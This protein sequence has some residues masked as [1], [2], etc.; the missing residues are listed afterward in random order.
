[1]PTPET[2]YAAVGDSDVAYQVLGRGVDDLLYFVGLGSHVDLQWDSPAL[3][4]YFDFLASLSR[5]IL[6]DR[7]GTGASDELQLNQASPPWEAWC[8][9]VAAV[10]NAVG[11]EHATIFAEVD[12]GPIAIL[13]TVSHPDRVRSLILGN[14]CARYLYNYD[15]EIGR[16]IEDLDRL[17]RDM[18]HSWGRA[19]AIRGYSSEMARREADIAAR[20]ARTQRAAATPRAAAAQ[21]RYILESLDVR[22]VLPLVRVPTLVLHTVGN[23]VVPLDH[24]RYLADHIDGA[25]FVE[26]K[27]ATVGLDP[28]D[29]HLM[30]E[31]GELLSGDRPTLP[32]SRILTTVLFTDV[33]D[34]T[35][36]A[37]SLGDSRWRG[38]LEAHDATV[39]AQ[40][41]AF[42]GREI[43]TMGDG[44][45]AEFDGPA[46]AIQCATSISHE[47]RRLGISVRCGVHTGECEVRGRDLAGLTVHIA[48]RIGALAGPDEVLASRTVTDIM[49]GSTL[50][51]APVGEH[52]LKG[53]PG[54]WM[55]FRTVS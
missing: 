34:S 27:G 24:G 5:L 40:L 49:A 20:V 2:R 41:R 52:Q 10:L 50:R 25:R 44:F 11:S 14:T 51:F 29:D 36:H 23:S 28:T 17:V 33:V 21:Y 15:Y 31:L 46:R 38:L 35:S 19:D 32:S 37:A 22:S 43:A 45:M 12:A 6:F 30:N 4:F 1:V 54:R 39:R 13:Y 8:E 42:R 3:S 18:A 47:V 7:R 16:P 55:L 9:D 26:L 48:A 53:V